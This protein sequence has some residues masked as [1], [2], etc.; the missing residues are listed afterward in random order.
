M[1]GRRSRRAVTAPARLAGRIARDTTFVVAGIPIQLAALVVLALPLAFPGFVVISLW[2]LLAALLAGL[3]AVALLR[4]PLTRAER[5]RLWSLL[6]LDIPRAAPLPG[7]LPQRL[8]ASLRAESAWRQLV[9]GPLL[10]LGGLATLIA[11]TAGA[12]FAAAYGYSAV[13]PR[14]S[15]VQSMSPKLR[16]ILTVAGVLLLAVAPVLAAAVTWL[17]ARCARALLGANRSLELERQ[18][19]SLAES[20]AGVVDAA[21]AERRRIERDLHDGAQ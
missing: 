4:L 17:D 7:S 8:L 6:G 12:A 11:W 14:F 5:H 2:Q 3:A 10:A 21:D 16:A 20:R 1:A 13:F 15:A 19:E 18:V 9:V